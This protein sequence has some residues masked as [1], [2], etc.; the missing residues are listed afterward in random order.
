[1]TMIMYFTA[2]LVFL[3]VFQASITALYKANSL[4]AKVS[5][6]LR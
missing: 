1:M 2:G 4:E 5:K 6:S 3:A